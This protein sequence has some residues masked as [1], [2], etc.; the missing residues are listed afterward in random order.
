M[1]GAPLGNLFAPIDEDVAAAT[2]QAG[3]D[4]GIRHFDTAPHY[5][6]GLS[7]LRMGAILRRQDRASF[8]LSTKVGRLL[9]PVPEVPSPDQGFFHALPF[10]RSFDYSAGGT[11][12][13]LEDSLAR[14]GLNR[15]DIVYIHDC[16]EDWHG[17]DWK[18]RFREAMQG[19]AKVLSAMRRRGEIQAWGL[20]VNL[21]EPA[22]AALE[23]SDPDIFLVA[24]RYTLLDHTALA[25]LFPACAARGAK[26]VL[27]GPYNSGLRA[28][29]TTFNY[30]TA[31]PDLAARA[32]ALGAACARHGVDLK[33][34]A[35]QFCAAHPVVAAVIPG[36][37]MPAEVRENAAMMRAPI[38]PALWADLR[39]AGLL[40]QEAPVP[41]AG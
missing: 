33:A 20:G 41:D 34:A 6:A 4:A 9:R 19:A 37:R 32:R 35:L 12:R 10:A 13:S 26:V 11:V 21:V 7:E 18:L 38:P 30:E 27:G 28:G 17:A 2:V 14:L 22:L 29:G 16:S 36:A 40:P 3:W 5:G 24:G 15:A 25:K 23:Q 1:G 8:H 31:P 39:R